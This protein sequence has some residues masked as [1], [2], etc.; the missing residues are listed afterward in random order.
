MTYLQLVTLLMAE[1][2]RRKKTGMSMT[3]PSIERDARYRFA[4][5]VGINRRSSADVYI[6]EIG[7]VLSENGYSDRYNELV[8]KLG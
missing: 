1:L 7:R 3:K 6:T 4:D 8:K 5:A 2:L